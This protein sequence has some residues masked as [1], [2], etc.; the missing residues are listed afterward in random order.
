[1]DRLENAGCDD[2]VLFP[3]SGGLEQVNLLAD[4]LNR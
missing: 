3:C 4:A 1:L 2:V